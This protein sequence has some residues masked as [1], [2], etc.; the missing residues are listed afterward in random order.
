MLAV[1]YRNLIR[2]FFQA[3]R[4][5]NNETGINASSESISKFFNYFNPFEVTY[6]W[7]DKKERQTTTVFDFIL[8]IQFEC[9]V[10]S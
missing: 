2:S 6:I 8:G 5:T 10:S 1:A 4:C 3:C 9:I 7:I